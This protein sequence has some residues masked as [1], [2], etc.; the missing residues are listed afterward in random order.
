[1]NLKEINRILIVKW[2]AL[3]D[4]VMSTSAIKTV[5]ENFPGAKITIVSNQLMKQILP[6]G[7]LC[8]EILII[9]TKG[10]RVDE[11]LK[12]QLKLITQLRRR[13][14][15]L[16]VNLRWT[17]E[18]GAMLA[19]LSGAKY[20]VSS[21][22]KNV[23][24]LYNIHA[25]APSGRY[26]EIHRNL[27]I[28]KAL[29]LI[30][31]DEIPVVHISDADKIFAKELFY[32]NRLN[33][34]QTVCIHP[35]ASRSIRA[36]MPDRFREIAKRITENL[37]ARVIV[38]WGGEEED[39]A[40]YVAE[41]SGENVLVCEKT[42]SVGELAAVIHNSKMFFS[43]CTGPMNVAVAVRTPVIALLG[44]SDPADWG[45]YGDINRYIKS[46][47]VLEHYSDED[48]KKAMEMI[49]VESVWDLV[50]KRWKEL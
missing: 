46:P 43:N 3:G 42:K 24:G 44:S 21:G 12:N 39:L 9:K 30:V 15:D 29:G 50:Q 34:N 33:K 26:H 2:G 31:N 23:M 22:P 4:I 10:N 48:E 28:V 1:M 11:P 20:R 25:D 16:A 27:D 32:K 47:L 14:F 7:F 5:R 18:R 19:Y 35:G 49:D 8:D 41:G 45:P 17:S 38:T 13:K 6:E 40:K 37:N 36:W